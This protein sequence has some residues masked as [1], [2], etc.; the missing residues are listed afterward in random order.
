MYQSAATPCHDIVID[1]LEEAKERIQQGPTAEVLYAFY[2]SEGEMPRTKLIPAKEFEARFVK[3]LNS[4]AAT[5]DTLRKDPAVALSTLGFDFKGVPPEISEA[6]FRKMGAGASTNWCAGCSACILCAICG[7][8][9]AISAAI[10]IEGLL[11]LYS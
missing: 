4:D 9:D 7:G 8:A 11:G 1:L 10:G 2:S 5:L 6:L 3:L